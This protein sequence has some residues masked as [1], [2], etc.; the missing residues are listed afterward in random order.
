MARLRLTHK[1]RQHSSQA[2]SQSP[3]TTYRARNFL[4]V[5]TTSNNLPRQLQRI[6]DFN[7]PFTNIRVSLSD[8]VSKAKLSELRQGVPSNV[9]IITPN[10]RTHVLDYRDQCDEINLPLPAIQ[11]EGKCRN[12]C[13]STRWLSNCQFDSTPELVNAKLPHHHNDNGL[14]NQIIVCNECRKIAHNRLPGLTFGA[15]PGQDKTRSHRQRGPKDGLAISDHL[16]SRGS[17]WRYWVRYAWTAVCRSC[18]FS[19]RSRHPDG[20]DGCRCHRERIVNKWLCHR[21]DEVALRKLMREAWYVRHTQPTQMIRKG[22]KM[23]GRMPSRGRLRCLCGNIITL[24]PRN[25]IRNVHNS[26]QRCGLCLGYIVP[27][28][29]GRQI[30]RSE[31]LREKLMEDM[32]R[33]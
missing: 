13:G 25:S 32:I 19:Q 29:H 3:P 16:P 22:A 2:S 15:G 20:F 17:A 12:K 21:C 1:Q 11:P 6:I 26:T 10:N 31:R 5:R 24:P 14:V 7:A 4:Y 18:D 27:M 33:S 28:L 8:S 30:R 9:S 23:T